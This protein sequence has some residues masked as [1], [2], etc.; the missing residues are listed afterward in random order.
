[1]IYLFCSAATPLYKR[2]ALES[3]CYPQHH[4][5]R[6]RYRTNYVD[7]HILSCPNNH[8][9]QEG[10]IVFLESIGKEGSK[11]FDFFPIRKITTIRLFTEG[12]AL[13]IDFSFGEFI[14]YGPAKDDAQ[15]QVWSKFFRNLAHRPWP[16]PHQSGRHVDDS[17]GYFILCNKEN[18]PSFPTKEQQSQQ[19]WESIISRLAVTKDLGDSTFFQILGFYRTKSAWFQYP[20]YKEVPVIPRNNSFE[21]IYPLPMGETIVLKLLFSRPTYDYKLESRRLLEISYGQDAFA[22]VSKSEISSESR[23]NQERII[24]VCKRVLDSFLSQVSIEQKSK[25]DSGQAPKPFLLISIQVQKWIVSVVVIGV[26][27]STLL[28]AMDVDSIKFLGTIIF[29]NNTQ[30]IENNAKVLSTIAK[31]IA[32]ITISVSAFFAFRRLPIK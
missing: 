4:L 31:A 7:P 26:F 17:E 20:P 9:Q 1:M 32:S 29:P 13:Y 24:L 19:A 25:P 2:D 18:N 11:D 22:G 28:V 12:Q 3:T 5:F 23:Y 6:F 30:F 16:Q 15:K 14:N 8:Q 27:L 10:V 21:S